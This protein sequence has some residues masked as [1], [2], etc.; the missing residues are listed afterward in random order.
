MRRAQPA[1]P[2]V[3]DPKMALNCFRP[4]FP[5]DLVVL[6]SALARRWR[7]V[8]RHLPDG[9]KR[10]AQKGHKSPH[11]FGHSLLSVRTATCCHTVLHVAT[12][13]Y[14][15]PYVVTC[16]PH[17]PMKHWFGGIAALL[18]RPRLSWPRLEAV[19][20][21]LVRRDP[22]FNCYMY[23]YVLILLCLLYYYYICTPTETRGRSANWESEL[24]R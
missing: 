6:Q 11:V 22:V 15:L 14:L 12:C 4:G 10:G 8:I 19:E 1:A 18:W 13:C 20:A 7:H 5:R 17:F 9:D 16:C 3:G 24:Q 23:V 2:L 21:P